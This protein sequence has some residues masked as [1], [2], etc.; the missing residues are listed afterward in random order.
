MSKGRK[1]MANLRNK[2]RLVL[3]NDTHFGEVFSIRLTPMNLLMLL[4][5]V[6][7]AFVLLIYL[8]I[9]FT[10]AKRLVPGFGNTNNREAMMEMNQRVEDLS[11]ELENKQIKIDA[12][13]DILSEREKKFDSTSVRRS[14]N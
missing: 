4:S 5:S 7:L 8:L 11:R 10:P 3:L 14:R 2:Y 13:N 6:F 9:S 12:L 1:I